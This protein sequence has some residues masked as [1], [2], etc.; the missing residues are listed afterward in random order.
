MVEQVAD[1]IDQIYEIES[2]GLKSTDFWERADIAWSQGKDPEALLLTLHGN[3]KENE[4]G[5]EECRWNNEE[6]KK[7]KARLLADILLL[8]PPQ[9]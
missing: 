9:G 1:W 2:H 3:G 7:R 6:E 5:R 4:R 8:Y